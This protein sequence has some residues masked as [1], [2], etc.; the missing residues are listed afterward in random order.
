[1]SC[2]SS[3]LLR[4]ATKYSSLTQDGKSMS[5]KRIKKEEYINISYPTGHSVKS[6]IILFHEICFLT[7]V[8]V[9]WL[10]L[11]TLKG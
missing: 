11:L 9:Q 10:C 3:V 2:G 4:S 7:S 5:Q 1:M 6:H 8:V